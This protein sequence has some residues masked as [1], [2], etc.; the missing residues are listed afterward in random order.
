MT[1][2]CK[3]YI[4]KNKDVLGGVILE[5]DTEIR[6]SET[7]K[8]GII[9][10]I[11]NLFLFIIKIIISI[12]SK[13]QSM[14]AD[15]INSASDILSSLMTYIGGKISGVPSDYNH[16]YGHGKAEYIFSMIISLI[17]IYLSFTIAI[18]GVT[19][20]IKQEAF[21]FS[22]WL[23]MVCFVTIVV[24]TALYL[25]THKKG[26]ESENI[27]ILA[28][29]QD[30]I[31]DVLVTLSVL[32]GVVAALFNIYWLD[33]I[34]AVG[35]A[36]RICYVGIQ[37]FMESYKVLMD[38]SMSE[39]EKERIYDI[40]KSYGEI[41]HIDKVTSKSVGNKYIVIVKVSVEGNMTVNESH[42]IAGMLKADILK[43]KNIYDVV[44]H[45][46]PV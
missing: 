37:F 43:I 3:L 24:K 33:G 16:D 17:T 27:L 25:Y 7:K 22:I 34:V 10:I 45:I 44:V 32:V 13:S 38:T 12:I 14:F 15:S 21:E 46:N 8:I 19:S 42:K 2:K 39:G 40:V 18:K 26:K 30:H 4:I 31:N 23:V 29:A 35:I 5:N 1:I 11:G 36:A 6:S 20:L 9:G 28:N 41:D